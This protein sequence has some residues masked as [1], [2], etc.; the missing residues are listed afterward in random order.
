MAK[1]RIPRKK[2]KYHYI[3]KALRGLN[4]PNVPKLERYLCHKAITS[5]TRRY[6]VSAEELYNR[7]GFVTMDDIVWWH[8]VRK[9]HLGI[10]PKMS[11]EFQ[12]YWD[13]FV[14]NGVIK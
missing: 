2:K 4:F 13:Y 9:K 3:S 8:W 12:E 5:D 6:K 1:I 10:E 11:K 7:L 14:S